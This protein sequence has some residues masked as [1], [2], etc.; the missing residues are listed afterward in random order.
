MDG[1]ESNVASH[2]KKRIWTSGNQRQHD[3]GN[4][5]AT[6]RPHRGVVWFKAKKGVSLDFYHSKVPWHP[7]TVTDQILSQNSITLS[8][9]SQEENPEC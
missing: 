9:H 7:V 8:S 1:T 2:A 6:T 3:R 5:E 4:A